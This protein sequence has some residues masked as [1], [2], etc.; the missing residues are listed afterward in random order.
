M[1]RLIILFLIF[2][3][4]KLFAQTSYWQQQ[5]NYNIEVK[6][7]TLNSSL[8]GNLEIE[9]INN[10]PDTLSYIWF[11]VWPNA[12]KND[13]T[14]FSEQQLEN[15]STDFYFSND[16]K[17][18]Y[19]NKLNFNVEGKSALIENNNDHQD[20]IKLILPEKLLPGS[21][22]KIKTNFH[23]KLN[24][25]FS[26]GGHINKSYQIT[27]WYPK[28]AVYDK[29]GWHPMPYLDQGEFYS[30]FG[31]YTVKITIPQNYIVA[32]SGMRN[33][34]F[35]EN[36]EKTVIYNQNNIH[37]FAWFADKDF[38]VDH[39]TLQLQSKVIDVYAYYYKE[40]SNEWKNALKF[41]K[42]AIVTKSNW[43]GEYPYSSVSVVDSKV[44]SG[45][46]MEYPMITLISTMTDEKEM[47]LLINHEVGHNWFYGIIATNERQHPWMDEGMN[48]YY[49]H[50]YSDEFY[51][52][53]NNA[54]LEKIKPKSYEEVGLATMIALKKD[55]PIETKSQ[56]FNMYN[57]SLIAYEKTAQWMALL[58]RE[59]SSATF[60]LLMKEYFKEWG[61]KHPHPEDFK[62]LAERISG[63]DLTIMFNL[64]NKKGSLQPKKNK[65]FKLASFASLK[66]TDRFN[67]LFL[68]PALGYNSYDKIMV[69]FLMHN[70][71]FP[72]PKFKY[73]IT[74]LYSPAS[75]SLNGIGNIKYSIPQNSGASLNFLLGF[76]KF[77]NGKYVDDEEKSN[78]LSFLKIAPG[79]EYV[80]ANR[81]PR[82][83]VR[84]YLQF[85][86]FLINEKNILF[87]RD[88][89][90]DNITYPVSKTY[91]NQL[92]AGF[93]NNRKLYPFSGIIQ[94]QQGKDFIKAGFTGK[95]FLNYAKG[96]G[97][98]VRFFAGKFIYT[99]EKTFFSQYQTERYHLNMT[100]ANGYEDF[101]Y[102]D[103]FIGRNIFQGFESQQIKISD[104]GFKV[105]T[106]LLSN[107][108]GRTDDWLASLNFSSTIPDKINPLSILPIKI[109]IRVFADIGSYNGAWEKYSTTGKF[110]YDAGIQLSFL[111]VINIYMPLI[112]SKVYDDYFKSTI[113]EKR[114][115]K[116]ISF[117]LDINNL[118]LRKFI[119]QSPL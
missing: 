69:G 15:G 78:F 83:S 103:Y 67:Y 56:D 6:L 102:S 90:T 45:G 115:L 70:Y 53:K 52:Q 104:G 55:Q 4:N 27:Q 23:V 7:D 33:S 73:F 96:G 81:S 54:L 105:R 97:V 5:V 68:A 14:D 36:E 98:D 37:D 61:F 3:T 32:S 21:I 119:Q 113:T 111:R 51:P 84:K 2:F 12:Y 100:G 48:S 86:T 42:R 116:K 58:E 117:S 114:F 29:N 87:S 80:F 93:E 19:I 112:Y 110:L 24:Y 50:K 101:T 31:N 99:T 76:S 43:I 57:Y 20:I 41:I 82:S 34:E 26:R 49:D 59:I 9:Y 74:P 109:P 108:I 106:D 40:N 64:L 35:V 39:D 13:K 60:N 66:D 11:H 107:K 17:K 72:L 1:K 94:V 62:N 38:I 88:T 95:Y 63:R 46:G 91:I 89:M 75:K 77:S 85:K 47:D 71:T 79:I 65:S 118:K 22:A 18:G 10:S 92:E 16:D 30:E 8:D 25:N 44:P 28:P